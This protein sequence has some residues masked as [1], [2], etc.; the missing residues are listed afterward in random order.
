MDALPEGKALDVL[1]VA[2][3][4]ADIPLA[5]LRGVGERI[6]RLD[7][8]DPAER[9]LEVGR[10]KLARAGLE[11]RVQLSMASAENLPF[12]DAAFDAVTVVFGVRNFDDRDRAL[13]E[14][15]RV[16]KPGGRLIVL[17]FG[18][19][20]RPVRPLYLMYLRHVLP[21]VGGWLA[22]SYEDFRYLQ[23]SIEQFPYGKAFVDILHG[24]GFSSARFTPLT[25]GAVY[26]YTA[27]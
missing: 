18:M 16:L 4:T 17:E 6:G 24:A 3:G 21:R 27:E 22:G 13:R 8:I 19:P 26:L 2:T 25:L 10:A 15:R 12:D 20:I 11:G 5:L 7:G 9:M 23:S 1:D 14:M